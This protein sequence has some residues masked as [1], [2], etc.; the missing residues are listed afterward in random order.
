LGKTK[1]KIKGAAGIFVNQNYAEN[2][3]GRTSKIEPSSLLNLSTALAAI[4]IDAKQKILGS[5]LKCKCN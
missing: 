1:L 3:E 4:S 2:N 5:I